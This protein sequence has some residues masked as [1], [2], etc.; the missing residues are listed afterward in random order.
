MNLIFNNVWA[1]L[2]SN[3][4]N[5]RPRYIAV[6]YFSYPSLV[7]DDGDILIVN[8]SDEAIKLGQTT[9]KALRQ[10]YE[11][12]AKIFSH[13]NLHAKIY[14]LG[15]RI[16]VGSANSSQSS[17]RDLIEC[18]AS[19]D[20][21]HAVSEDI[22]FVDVLSQK[23]TPVCDVFLSRVDKI[24]INKRPRPARPRPALPTVGTPRCWLL[25]IDEE[26][27]YPGTEDYIDKQNKY[28]QK[29]LDG[30]G[31]LEEAHSFWW[32]HRKTKFMHEA[33]VGDLLIYV[34]LPVW[35]ANPEEVYVYKHARIAAITQESQVTAKVF[36]L[37]YP[38]NWDTTKLR[39]SGF[40]AL[41]RSAGWRRELSLHSH[42]E[43]PK[44][45][46]Q[47]IYERWD[48]FKR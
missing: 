46:S 30:V 37:A 7:F 27:V 26:G 11:A 36:H 21:P 45:V 15:Q 18:L 35:R 31:S 41:M 12:G 28:L 39:W 48:T 8:A 40:K 6:A 10:A 5:G 16:W 29:E 33:R 23:A 20:D 38:K 14:I 44:W 25:G 1:D 42:R 4:P 3:W 43:I 9:A 32:P 17:R 34:N 22:C 47:S 13:S 2:I 24:P 19:S